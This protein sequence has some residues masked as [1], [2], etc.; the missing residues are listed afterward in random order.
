[1]EQEYKYLVSESRKLHPEISDEKDVNAKANDNFR[2]VIHNLVLFWKDRGEKISVGGQIIL[3][4]GV[5]KVNS[6]KQYKE[7]ARAMETLG[8][9][10]MIMQGPPGTSKTSIRQERCSRS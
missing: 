2:D 4:E 6:S 9:H 3:V 10:Q 5:Y 8:I 7:Y 1:M